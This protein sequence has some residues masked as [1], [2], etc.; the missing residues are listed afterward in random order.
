MTKKNN[1]VIPPSA[2]TVPLSKHAAKTLNDLVHVPFNEGAVKRVTF[3]DEEKAYF[4]IAVVAKAVLCHREL[5]LLAGREESNAVVLMF[6][7]VLSQQQVK[8]LFEKFVKAY[9]KG[10]HRLAK[11]LHWKFLDLRAIIKTKYN[12][13]TKLQHLDPKNEQ[14]CEIRNAGQD[15]WE[16]VQAV[17]KHLRLGLRVLEGQQEGVLIVGK[18]ADINRLRESLIRMLRLYPHYLAIKVHESSVSFF[19]GSADI[20]EVVAD[21]ADEDAIYNCIDEKSIIKNYFP[22][23]TTGASG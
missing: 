7:A 2:P 17:N 16:L 19:S 14:V 18:T 20:F 3:E 21:Y 15:D 11:Q 1:E 8:L 10:I 4:F 23:N 13:R 5:G 6:G 22:S 9:D 12:S